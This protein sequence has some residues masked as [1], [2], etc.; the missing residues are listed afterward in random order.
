[1]AALSYGDGS[2]KRSANNLA[3]DNL[4]DDDGDENKMSATML[5]GSQHMNYFG[6]EP[7]I[8][9]FDGRFSMQ[10]MLS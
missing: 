3:A 9:T 5:A 4:A 8:L 7:S 10:F 2:E 6:A 1:M